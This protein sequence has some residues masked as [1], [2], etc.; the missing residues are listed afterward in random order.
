MLE[1]NLGKTILEYKVRNIA[2]FETDRRAD[3]VLFVID[4]YRFML[5][6]NLGKTILEY[7]VRFIIF[8]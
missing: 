2:L 8:I 4:A 1:I 6:I 7:K 5:E 3:I